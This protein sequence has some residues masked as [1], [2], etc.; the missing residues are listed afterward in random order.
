M[1]AVQLGRARCQIIDKAESN[2]PRLDWINPNI[3]MVKTFRLKLKDTIDTMGTWWQMGEKQKTNNVNRSAWSAALLGPAQGCQGQGQPARANN[4]FNVQSS[5]N[6]LLARCH[7]GPSAACDSSVQLGHCW[8][9][10]LH[11]ALLYCS[12]SAIL[13]SSTL[14]LHLFYLFK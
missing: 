11:Q 2:F 8:Y 13:S 4:L 14:P 3:K 12:S 10:D 9:E 7:E 6:P 1:K 5:N